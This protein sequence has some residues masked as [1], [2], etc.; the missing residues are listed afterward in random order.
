MV[1]EFVRAIKE[2]NPVA[3]LMENVKAIESDIHKFFV[4]EHVENTKFAYSS[5]KHL[6]EITEKF[7]EP[8]ENFVNHDN[9][10]LV[11]TGYCYLENVFQ[12]L[13]RLILF[14]YY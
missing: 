12:K 8:L 10:S 14:P 9:I 3:L 11:E 6:T 1:K 7:G 13:L 5:E 2:I 4:T